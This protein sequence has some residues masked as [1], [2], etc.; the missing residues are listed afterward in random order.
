MARDTQYTV[1]VSW[2][3]NDEIKIKEISAFG[4]LSSDEDEEP[5]EL[6]GEDY[7]HISGH[8]TIG[9]E[10]VGTHDYRSYRITS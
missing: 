4:E 8:L 5:K 7:S 1:Y 6:F 2:V 10:L 3:E 9:G